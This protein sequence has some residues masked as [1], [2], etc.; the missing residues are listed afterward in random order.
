MKIGYNE[1]TG[2]KC[3]SLAQDL[4][5]CEE[6]G[7]DFIEIRLDMLQEYLKDHA[8]QELSYF[9]D[10][11]RLK[12]H[13]LN[14]IYLYSEFLS[15][16]DSLEKQEKLLEEFI[17]ACQVG[18]EI[19]SGFLVVVPPLHRDPKEGPF[20]GNF[21]DTFI[22]CVRILT[23]L[24]DLAKP[25][26]MKLCFEVV[27]FD[28]SSVR[29]V[30]EANRIVQ[31]VGRD[32]VGFVFDSYNLYLN[33]GLNHFEVFQ[34]VESSK[35]FAVHINSA[36]DAPIHERGQDKRCFCGNGVVNVAGFLQEIKKTGYEGMISIETFRPE[37]WQLSP[38]EV[39]RT[40]FETTRECLEKNGC[41]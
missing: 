22:H 40:A 21:E 3:S 17:F 29:S 8:I 16:K 14:A 19:E 23:H 30:E 35:I 33:Q 27:G 25:Y 9:F 28:R 26:G 39:I 13:A 34:T 32:N 18:K 7:F 41:L 2:M 1:A 31:A 24:S 15:E 4:I 38:Q 5:L 36:D 10:R 37:Y 20:S 12:P 11:S 6:V